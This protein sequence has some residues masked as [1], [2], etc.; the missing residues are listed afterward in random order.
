MVCAG[1]RSATDT[2]DTCQGDS[3][4]SLSIARGNSF[5][6]VG[7]SSFGGTQ[8]GHLVAPPRFPEFMP[9]CLR[10]QASLS[11]MQLMPLLPPSKNP[12]RS[13]QH[14]RGW[15]SSDL[16]VAFSAGAS[17]YTPFYASLPSQS[18]IANVDVGAVNTLSAPLPS[19]SAS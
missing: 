10:F 18:P 15:H 6:Q 8:K 11:S 13:N 9:A 2:S 16:N 17:G 5:V 4:G 19:G 3:G 14:Q 1:G 7:L 12:T